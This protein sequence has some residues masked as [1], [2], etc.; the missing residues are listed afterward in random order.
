MKAFLWYVGAPLLIN[1]AAALLAAFLRKKQTPAGQGKPLRFSLAAVASI[2]VFSALHLIVLLFFHVETVPLPPISVVAAS[3]CFTVGFALPGYGDLA[4][5]RPVLTR[6]FKRVGALAVAALLIE[7]A[8]CNFQSV[9]LNDT[10]TSLSPTDGTVLGGAQLTDQGLSMGV[11]STLSFTR[12]VEG[13]TVTLRFI[14]Q[15]T[16]VTV[17]IA[18]RDDNFS[19]SLKTLAEQTVTAAHGWAGFSIGTYGMIHE[20]RITVSGITDPLVLQS[21]SVSNAAPFAFNSLRFLLLLGVAI[22]IAV[23]RLGRLYRVCYDSRDPRH[24]L[25]I[26]CCL[27]LCLSVHTALLSPCLLSSKEGAATITYPFENQNAGSRDAYV[28]QFDAFY[29]GQLHLDIEPNETLTALEDPYDYSLRHG[30][31]TVYY[32]WDR[33]YYNGKYYSYF[34]VAPL[35]TFYVPFYWITGALPSVSVTCGFFSLI[36]TVFLFLLLLELVRRFCGGSI[37]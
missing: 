6:F 17:T 4:V 26:A 28:Q 21:V 27:V 10:G 2:L 20:L 13:D 37:C 35:L 24:H 31:G 36:A 9:S 7:T 30:S 29:K 16:M 1:A 12:E 22:V 11:G 15:D 5:R 8:V 33:A 18:A 25:L 32:Q 23:V 3:L 34:G 14:P 19:Q